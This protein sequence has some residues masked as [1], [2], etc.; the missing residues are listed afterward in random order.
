[1]LAYSSIAH[2]GYILMAIAAAGSSVNAEST[3]NAVSMYLMAYMFTNLGAFAVSIAIEKVDGTGTNLNDLVGLYRTQPQLALLMAWFMLSLTGI[4]LT[5][6]FIGKYFVFSA[7]VQ[8]ELYPLAIVGTHQRGER[9]LL[10]AR[11]HQYVLAR[12]STGRSRRRGNPLLD[13][14]GVPLCCWGV[15]HGSFPNFGNQPLPNDSSVNSATRFLIPHAG[16]SST[17]PC[18]WTVTF[19][20]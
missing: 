4:P 18:F 20:Y 1:M 14:C 15:G 17:F 8:A 6:G 3:L 2:A 16:R 13:E 5:G 12:R 19:A 7:A 11:G 9:V 10:H